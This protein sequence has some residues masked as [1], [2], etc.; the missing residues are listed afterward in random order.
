LP[1]EAPELVEGAEGDLPAAGHM[2]DPPVEAAGLRTGL[3]RELK[4]ESVSLRE[5]G[6]GRASAVSA[7]RFVGRHDST[8]RAFGA[9][10]LVKFLRCS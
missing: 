1:D 2:L 5:S 10:V 8:I 9:R 4:D 3:G 6:A 7:G